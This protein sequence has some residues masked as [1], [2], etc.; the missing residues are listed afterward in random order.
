MITGRLYRE[1]QPKGEP[2]DLDR[3]DAWIRGNGGFAWVDVTDPDPTD[4]GYLE[5]TFGLHPVTLE[6]AQ[7][8]HQRTKVE[9]FEGYAFVVLRP[10]TMVEGTATPTE[11]EIHA[12]AGEGF[13]VTV[14]WT[15]RYPLDAVTTRWQRRADLHSAG[16]AL[17]VLLDEVVD[18][19]LSAIEV[20]EDEADALEDVVFERDESTERGSQVQERLFRLKRSTV[21][22][23]R[24]A[25]P[26]RYGID[27]L[28]E[29]PAFSSSALA[30][31]FR[32][33]MDHVIRVAELADNVRDLLTSMLE[34]RVAQAANRLNEVMKQLSAW[35]A[36]VLVPTLIAGIY[37]M[38][39][40]DMPE[41]RWQLGYPMA[42]G[43]MAAA[44]LALYVTFKKRGWL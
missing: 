16:F 37:G 33:V 29:E 41:L 38:N 7:H 24:S 34:V 39:F 25:A 5:R 1:G 12:I 10:V 27:L 28:Q 15:P 32:D 40:R 8:R 3:A 13:L 19:Y 6:D 18:D 11:H 2:L 21:L 42:L 23:R 22:L 17:Y 20:L 14:R 30:P 35:A 9:L 31:Y 43:I 44:A 36:I 26:L 4:L